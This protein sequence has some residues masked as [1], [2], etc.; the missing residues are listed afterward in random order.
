VRLL[1][2]A[3]L[4]AVA[5]ASATARAGTGPAG[6]DVGLDEHLGAIVPLDLPFTD[7]TGRRVLLA[8]VIGGRRPTLL[9]MAYAR[10]QML[11]SVV[12]EGVAEAVRASDLVPG[13]DYQLVVVSLDPNETIGEARARQATLAARIGRRGDAAA[14]RYLIGDPAPVATLARA[15]GFRYAWDERTKQYAH[16]AVV[17]VLSPTGRISE[18][19]R[20]VRFPDGVLEAAL[21]RAS[22]GGVGASTSADLITC[23]HFDPALRHYRAR[24]EAYFQIGA[25]L[26]FFALAGAIA[27]LILW[28][29]RRGRRRA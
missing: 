15:L 28:E 6:L 26:V 14:W 4:A 3:S 10:C 9:V 20:G 18:Y 24:I 13:A 19:V 22:A 1:A 11:C 2:A 27:A 16:P 7:S 8:D 23:F 21:Q 29:R 25:A 12:L 17:F 5:L